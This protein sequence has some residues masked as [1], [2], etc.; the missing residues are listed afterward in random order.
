[1]TYLTYVWDVRG[2]CRYWWFSQSVLYGTFP[3]RTPIPLGKNL[4]PVCR[5]SGLPGEKL[6]VSLADFPSFINSPVVT[7][8]PSCSS[9]HWLTGM[10]LNAQKCHGA[11]GMAGASPTCPH[12]SPRLSQ[13]QALSLRARTLLISV[14]GALGQAGGK[15]HGVSASTFQQLHFQ[16][17]TDPFHTGDFFFVSVTKNS[18]L[19]VG[20]SQVSS[21]PLELPSAL[22]L[23]PFLCTLSVSVNKGSPLFFYF[24]GLLSLETTTTISSKEN[25]R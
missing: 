10:V 21:P 22:V 1:M 18:L 25:T 11:S 12:S 23:T 16:L 4:F 13:Q 14:P 19:T 9:C 3:L 8:D 7:A 17:P 20:F 15:W 6:T 2:L 24:L 5:G